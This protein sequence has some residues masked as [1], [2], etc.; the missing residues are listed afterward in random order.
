MADEVLSSSRWPPGNPLTVWQY[1]VS[2][3]SR[4]R[5][6]LERSHVQ[7]VLADL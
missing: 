1:D 5:A 3:Y 6:I 7:A 2:F 4:G